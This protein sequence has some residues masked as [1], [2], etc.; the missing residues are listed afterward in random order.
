MWQPSDLRSQMSHP[1]CPTGWRQAESQAGSTQAV[2]TLPG[3]ALRR[4]ETEP[5]ASV[6]VA[7]QKRRLQVGVQRG[8]APGQPRAGRWEG[9]FQVPAGGLE[10]HWVPTE[11]IKAILAQLSLRWSQPL[12][13]R[14]GKLS[15]AQRGTWHAWQGQQVQKQDQTPGLPGPSFL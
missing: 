14:L 2:R 6:Q 15:P 7:G 1:A 12:F 13:Y 10:G 8:G 4:L 3:V 9:R 11:L 5:L